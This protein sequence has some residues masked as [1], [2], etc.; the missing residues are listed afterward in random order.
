MWSYSALS[1]LKQAQVRRRPH[2]QNNMAAFLAASAPS[3]KTGAR[4]KRL[5]I[6]VNAPLLRFPNRAAARR[7]KGLP[8][9]KR[10]V[11]LDEKRGRRLAGNREIGRASCRE[12][13]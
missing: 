5:H 8:G 7:P 1:P 9:C 11:C 12:R 3:E 2:R 10:R 4:Y 6:D 13:V